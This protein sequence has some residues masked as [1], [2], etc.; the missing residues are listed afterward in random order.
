VLVVPAG[1]VA[2]VSGGWF[3]FVLAGWRAGRG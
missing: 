1:E 2:G 3:S